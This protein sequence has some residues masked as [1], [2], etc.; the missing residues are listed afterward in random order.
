MVPEVAFGDDYQPVFGC[1]LGQHFCHAVQQLY[2]LGEHFF[3]P[4]DYLVDVV[5]GDT[6]FGAGDGG[7]YER[8]GVSLHAVAEEFQVGA[9][10]MLNSGFYGCLGGCSLTAR[11]IRA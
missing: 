6:T 2:R 8:E 3:A 1:Q 7:F 11:S 4:L 9:L 5:G 10:V